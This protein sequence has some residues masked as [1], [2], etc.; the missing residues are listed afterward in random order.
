MRTTFSFAPSF[1]TLQMVAISCSVLSL[2]ACKS[3][4]T[5]QTSMGDRDNTIPTGPPVTT[6]STPFTPVQEAVGEASDGLRAIPM[7]LNDLGGITDGLL[8]G[9]TQ[10]ADSGTTSPSLMRSAAP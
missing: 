1:K 2:V 9:V 6:Q 7:L 10:L 4:G 3:N 8:G 5:V